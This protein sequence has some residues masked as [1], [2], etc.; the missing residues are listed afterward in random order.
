MGNFASYDVSNGIRRMNICVFLKSKLDIV[1]LII[2]DRKSLHTKHVPLHKT[3]QG[4]R[5]CNNMIG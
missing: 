5:F 3:L 1:A 4:F 2:C